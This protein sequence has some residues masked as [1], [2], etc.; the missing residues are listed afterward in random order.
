[1]RNNNFESYNSNNWIKANSTNKA[2]SK[3]DTKGGALALS[4]SGELLYRLTMQESFS[5]SKNY[6]ALSAT[7][8]SL[9]G[10]EIELLPN[11]KKACKKEGEE[12]ALQ[13][14]PYELKLI[15]GEVFSPDASEE[16]I[17]IENGLFHLNLFRPSRF[18][19]LRCYN[20]SHDE[21]KIHLSATLKLIQHLCNNNSEKSHWLIN[22][23]AFFFKGLK[24][25]QVALVLRGDQ[26]S[27]K[28][29]FF[30]EIIK[31]LIGEAYA[32]IINDKSLNSSYLGGL[33]ENTLFF[34]LDEISV[35]KSENARVKNFLKAIVTNDS[36]TVE[37]K[38]KTLEKETRLYAQVLITSNET[39]PVEIEPSDRRFSVFTTGGALNKCNFLGY[40]SYEALSSAMK[41]EL[42]TFICYL[43]S[44]PVNEKM[45]NTPLHTQE[46][47]CLI[48][49]YQYQEQLK[50][51]KLYGITQPKLTKLEQKI[52]L[53]ATAIRYKQLGVF[54]PL[55]FEDAELYYMVMHDINHHLFRVENLL[56][57]FKKLY[58][59]SQIKT[60]P[61]L[62]RELQRF[63]INSFGLNN[64]VQ[65]I[66][67]QT[68]YECLRIHV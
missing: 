51:N 31:L 12:Q 59:V 17:E 29:M 48:S 20:T 14:A 60:T 27:G 36:I 67:N 52:L 18:L 40:G 32:K 62:L 33:V 56:P 39:F 49:F 7:F 26:G 4:E 19:Q 68:T 28:G 1:M 41:K 61:E 38:F 58:G 65:V 45:A 53:Y 47:D 30:N 24:K 6:K 13:I 43:K 5:R 64:I 50:Y 8:S 16:F 57:I 2:L 3:I 35:K 25:S 44:F 46:K 9:I 42:E 63:D 23:L 10:E 21:H 15:T 37:K 11:K 34:N 22:W 66:I 55:R 54:E